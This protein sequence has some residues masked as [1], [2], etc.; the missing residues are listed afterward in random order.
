MRASFPELR[1]R[2]LINGDNRPTR[3]EVALSHGTGVWGMNEPARGNEGFE[4]TPRGI[5]GEE[6]VAEEEAA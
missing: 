1:T 3:L 2:P 6:W 5:P 4:H